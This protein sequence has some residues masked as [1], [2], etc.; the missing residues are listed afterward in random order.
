[1]E[2]LPSSAAPAAFGNA[3]PDYD[4]AEFSA[5]ALPDPYLDDVLRLEVAAIELQWKA[6]PPVRVVRFRNDPEPLLTD[7]SEGRRPT[8]RAEPSDRDYFVLLDARGGDIRLAVIEGDI[9]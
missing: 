4:S 6:D 9:P 7:L 2:S 5:G 3:G 1:M 8:R